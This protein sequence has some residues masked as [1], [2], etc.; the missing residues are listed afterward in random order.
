MISE[1][2]V[3]RANHQVIENIA[4]SKM[5]TKKADEAFKNSVQAVSDH[6][7]LEVQLIEASKRA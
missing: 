2:L 5:L 1:V 3:N 4:S 6:F 7:H